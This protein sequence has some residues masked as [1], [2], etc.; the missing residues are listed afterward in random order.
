MNI[1]S[2][3]ENDFFLYQFL[4]DER[5]VNIVKNVGP[6]KKAYI[7]QTEAIIEILDIVITWKVNLKGSY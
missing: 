6:T 4:K 3:L 1:K 2:N 5:M 7:I